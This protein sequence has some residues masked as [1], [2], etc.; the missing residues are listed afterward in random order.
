M[1]SLTSM[2]RRY[3]GRMAPPP[4][5]FLSPEEDSQIRE[6]LDAMPRDGIFVDL[7]ANV[8]NVT[9]VALEYGHKV[10]AFEPGPAWPILYK[11]FG[12][13]PR[14]TLINKAIGA[15]ARVVDFHIRK[16]WNTHD[17]TFVRSY[18][19]GSSKR[20]EV[21][22]IVDFLR[23][24]GPVTIVKMDIEGAEAECLEAVVESGVYREVGLF[25]AET[26]ERF[27]DDIAQRIDRIKQQIAADDIRNMRLDWS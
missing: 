24:L 17:A 11:R 14:V 16:D 25:L 7:G 2:Y 1:M 27:S 22:P 13:D 18:E 8:G 10:Y 20:V 23:S 15:T 5:L 21:V 19:R 4:P 6:V 9:S 26:H 3:F 12:S